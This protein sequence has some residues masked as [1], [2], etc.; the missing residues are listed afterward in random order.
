VDL[1][2]E[3]TENIIGRTICPLGEAAA[4]PIQGFLKKFRDEFESHIKE[5]KCV[6]PSAGESGG[7][8]PCW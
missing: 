3:I 8:T 2:Q 5:K 7:F 4:M 1:L 6:L